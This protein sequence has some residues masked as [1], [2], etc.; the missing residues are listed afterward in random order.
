[1]GEA[2]AKKVI[3][4]GEGVS[5]DNLLLFSQMKREGDKRVENINLDEFIMLN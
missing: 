1:L 4:M 5:F 3:D 2:D